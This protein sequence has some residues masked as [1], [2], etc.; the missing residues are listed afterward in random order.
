MQATPD[1][2]L[3]Q[4]LTALIPIL[5]TVLTALGTWLVARINSKLKSEQARGM[6]LRLS[7]QAS[8]VV[9]EIEQNAVSKLR[10]ATK[11]GTLDASD[12]QGLKTEALANFK[13]YL[14]TNGKADALKVLGFRDEKEL[15]DLLRAKLEAEV[16][17]L[18]TTLGQRIQSK[19][20]ELRS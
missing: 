11:D 16:Q 6:L 10:D 7:E 15:E 9:R 12:V 13:A 17:K 18:K 19:V 2:P 1:S 8:D 14:G 20:D 5:I 3:S 4:I